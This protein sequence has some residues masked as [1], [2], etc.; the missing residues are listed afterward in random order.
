MT[1]N[2]DSEGD[3]QPSSEGSSASPSAV[4][5]KYHFEGLQAQDVEA[6]QVAR[7]YI[8]HLLTVHGSASRVR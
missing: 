1:E 7:E 3:G 5:P 8:D 2:D 6:L 4:L